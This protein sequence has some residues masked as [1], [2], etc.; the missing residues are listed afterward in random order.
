MSLGA[1]LAQT[2]SLL[3]LLVASFLKATSPLASI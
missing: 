3:A 1:E 2:K